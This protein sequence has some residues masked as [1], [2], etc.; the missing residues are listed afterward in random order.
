[1]EKFGN[2]NY[3]AVSRPNAFSVGT[4][5]VSEG[6]ITRTVDDAALALSALSGY[7]TRDPNSIRCNNNF[8]DRISNPNIKNWKIAYSPNFDVFPVESEIK[9]VIGA[10]VRAFEEVGAIVE[11]V[12][13]GI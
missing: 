10:Q 7:D 12:T 4:P 13:L 3:I 6:P 2:Y 11:P 9:S 1:M 5:F 8:V